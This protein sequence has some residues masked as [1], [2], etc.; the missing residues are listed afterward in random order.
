MDDIRIEDEVGEEVI[1]EDGGLTAGDGGVVVRFRNGSF[2]MLPKISKVGT[3]EVGE[4]DTF[5]IC[6]VG[7]SCEVAAVTSSSC[8]SVSSS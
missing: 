4:E 3:K 5:R 2:R 6:S 8:L 7:V 1:G